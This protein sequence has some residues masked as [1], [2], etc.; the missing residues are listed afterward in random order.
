MTGNDFSRILNRV[1][2]GENLGLLSF[3]GEYKIGKLINDNKELQEFYVD[4]KS[5]IEVLDKLYDLSTN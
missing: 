4:E 1:S 2:K 3:K 5:R